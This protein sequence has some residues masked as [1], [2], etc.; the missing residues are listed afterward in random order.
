M[1]VWLPAL[2]GR[3]RAALNPDQIERQP[4]P[5]A[6]LKA[7]ATPLICSQPLKPRRMRSAFEIERRRRVLLS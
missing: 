2:A 3:L 4:H 7:E 6:S 5:S 1:I